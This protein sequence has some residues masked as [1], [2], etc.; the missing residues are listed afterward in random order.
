MAIEVTDLIDEANA[1]Y[2]NGFVREGYDDLGDAPCTETMLAALIA[3]QIEDLFDVNSSD[4]ANLRRIT[5]GLQATADNLCA[6]VKHLQTL[7]T[8]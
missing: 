7:S 3:A 6:V 8:E 4:A 5:A 1:A 2:K